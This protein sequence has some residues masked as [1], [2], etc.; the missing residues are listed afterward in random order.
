MGGPWGVALLVLG[1]VAGA[2]CLAVVGGF[3]W[4]GRRRGRR[5]GGG[6]GEEAAALSAARWSAEQPESI[7]L[8]GANPLCSTSV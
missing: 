8:T 4:R 3:A 2:V 1:G 6:G 7:E 5:L